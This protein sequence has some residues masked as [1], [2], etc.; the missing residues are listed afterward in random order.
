MFQIPETGVT[1]FGVAVMVGAPWTHV[2]LNAGT[3]LE[4]EAR[5]SA[6]SPSRLASPINESL[7]HANAMFGSVPLD[8]LVTENFLE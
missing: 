3:L 4:L 6:S 2:A 5:P 1:A 7:Q 8:Q